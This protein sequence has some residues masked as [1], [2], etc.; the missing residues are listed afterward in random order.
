[1]ARNR[2]ASAGELLIDS[3]DSS[4]MAIRSNLSRLEKRRDSFFG[5][6]DREVSMVSAVTLLCI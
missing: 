3:E 4:E 6:K 5:A 1:M 2:A